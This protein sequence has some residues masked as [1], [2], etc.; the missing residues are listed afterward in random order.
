MNKVWSEAEKQFIVQN[1]STMKDD[2]IAARLTQITGRKVSLQAVRKQRQKMG[3]T[4]KPGRGV[5]AVKVRQEENQSA[6]NSRG[7]NSNLAP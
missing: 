6:D 4:K 1:A 3:I 2:E 7:V 5:C